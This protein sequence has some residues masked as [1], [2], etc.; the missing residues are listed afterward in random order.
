M[1]H[2]PIAGW[3]GQSSR[4]IVSLMIATGAPRSARVNARPCTGVPTA[5]KYPGVTRWQYGPPDLSCGMESRPGTE[6][7]QPVAQPNGCPMVAAAAAT[8]G[9]ISSRESICRLNWL[10]WSGRNPAARRSIVASSVCA[11]SNPKSC[12][13]TL[14]RLR[15]NSPA[16]TISVTVNAT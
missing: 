6:T 10:I 4:A 14:R 11:G 3:P 7:L 9:R 15:A 13:S 8:P 2:F 1:K 12:P 16:P 5:A